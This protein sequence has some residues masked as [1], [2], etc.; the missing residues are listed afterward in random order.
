MTIQVHLTQDDERT[1]RAL[2]REGETDEDV[3]R[4]ALHGLVRSADEEQA[5]A[6]AAERMLRDRR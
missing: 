2:P 4:R 1:L 5:R 3:L 6:E